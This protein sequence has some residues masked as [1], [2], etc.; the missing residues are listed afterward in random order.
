MTEPFA[1]LLSSI[2][3]SSIWDEDHETRI[4]WI[5][6]LAMADREGFVGAAITGISHRARVPLAATEK[7]LARFMAPDKFSR[8]PD[9]DGRRLERAEGGWRLLNYAKIRNNLDAVS[10]REYE[11]Q[12]KREQRA[13]KKSP[14]QS[15]D[16]SASASN[17]VS[18][19]ASGTV[20]R[21]DVAA[22]WREVTG[23]TDL[24]PIGVNWSGK[25]ETGGDMMRRW[26]QDNGGLDALRAQLRG[27]VALGDEFMSKQ[28]VL[29]WAE[30]VGT[31][32][33]D[34]E[35]VTGKTINAEAAEE[36]ARH[37]ETLRK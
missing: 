26:A 3:D 7:A 15:P 5:T 19:S 22:V 25:Q 16:S 32:V 35:K 20:E 28:G 18:A 17:S 14:G 11:A 2:T 34:T 30:R 37:R 4:V 36:L 1:K 8:N 21:E 12:R 27:L 9:N 23:R 6:L 24:P 13:R 29:Y 33:P 31:I 10:V